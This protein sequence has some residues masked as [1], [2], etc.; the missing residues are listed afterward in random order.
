[1]CVCV[2]VCVCM[3]VCVCVCVRERV[4]VLTNS[5]TVFSFLKEELLHSSNK[6]MSASCKVSTLKLLWLSVHLRFCTGK[7]GEEREREERERES[8]GVEERER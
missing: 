4:P 8:E 3:C 1:M 7:R 5:S 6:T 2:C